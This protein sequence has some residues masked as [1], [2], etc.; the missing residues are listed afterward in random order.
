MHITVRSAPFRRR[1]EMVARRLSIWGALRQISSMNAK[2]MAS[3]RGDG[4]AASSS[5]HQ[6]AA[7]PRKDTCCQQKGSGAQYHPVAC[8]TLAPLHPS[9]LSPR[10]CGRNGKGFFSEHSGRP[11][12]RKN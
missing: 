1:I 8:S 3:R 4:W 6:A 5:P 10:Q 11:Y 12:R 9:V 2:N 7:A